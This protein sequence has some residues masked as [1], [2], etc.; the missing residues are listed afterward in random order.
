M[1]RVPS[2][3]DSEPPPLFVT[4]FSL[5]FFAAFVSMLA[6]GLASTVRNMTAVDDIKNAK[7]ESTSC[8]ATS[9]GIVK[10]CCKNGILGQC[11]HCEEGSRDCAASRTT[12][13]AGAAASLSDYRAA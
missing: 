6:L 13:V 7:Y 2:R 1:A 5:I 11:S 8:N 10:A 12:K 9:A 4:L 3:R